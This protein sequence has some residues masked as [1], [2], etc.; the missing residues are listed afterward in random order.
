MKCGYM[1]K[2][3]EKCGESRNGEN[4]GKYKGKAKDMDCSI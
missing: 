1:E 4:I 3:Q 2:T